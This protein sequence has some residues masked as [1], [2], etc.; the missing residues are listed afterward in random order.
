MTVTGVD[1]DSHDGPQNYF[2]TVDKADSND[3]FYDSFSLQTVSL[4]NDDDEPFPELSIED[5]SA[6]EEAGSMD[7]TVS[8]SPKSTQTV[9]VRYAITNDTARRG[10]DYTASPA[11]ATLTFAPGEEQK[12]ISASLIDDNLDEDDET[13]TVT[14]SNLNPPEVQLAQDRATGTIRDNDEAA[15]SITD[16]DAFEDAGSVVFTVNLSLKSARTVTVG[17]AIADV[18]AREGSDY[19]ASPATGTLT[20][21][22][23][24]DQATISVPLRDDN[25]NEPEETFTV[26][27]SDPQNATLAQNRD[28]AT[29]TIMDNDEATLS[30]ADADA[31]ED[32]VNMDFT[33]SLSPQSTQEVRVRYTIT[34]ATAEKESDYTATPATATLTFSPGQTQKTVRVYLADDNI[35]EPDET[36]T[37]TLSDPRNAVLDQNRDTAT[38]TIRDN[39]EAAL[40]ITD[41]SGFEGNSINFTVTLSLRSTQ[42]GKRRIRNSGRHG[43]AGI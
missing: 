29:G 24:E 2:I 17:Y 18:T 35:D 41:A 1:D 6:G 7:F 27:L 3:R 42:D 31:L 20:F 39:D 13:F 40:S 4:R 28:T 10:P 8:L 34:G 33:V 19:T 16:A 15:L 37:A 26:T 23:E 25:I 30:I 5:V 36:L 21:A 22:P 14:L 43:T 32:A 9:T 11:T 12:T 38:G